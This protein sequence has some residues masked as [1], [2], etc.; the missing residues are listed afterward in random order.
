MMQDTVDEL[1]GPEG[2]AEYLGIPLLT[3]YGMNSKGTRP[4]PHQGR[5]ARPLPAVGHRRLAERQGDRVG[6]CRMSQT[7]R[8]GPRG[9]RFETQP[10][11]S[12]FVQIMVAQPAVDINLIGSPSRSSR[13]SVHGAGV[14]T[15]HCL[16]LC[17]CGSAFGPVCRRSAVSL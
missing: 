8:S 5:Q 2:L 4:S 13:C 17:Q 10:P 1:I 11:P 15:G 9:D 6:V 14:A 16:Q 7:E 3:V 12:A